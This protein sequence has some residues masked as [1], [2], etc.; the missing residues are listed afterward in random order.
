M[1]E[2]RNGHYEGERALFMI[3]DSLI[4]NCLFD[5]GESPLKEGKNLKVTNSIFGY[6]YPL[7]YNT[8]TTIS[9][10]TFLEMGR[11]GIW[12]GKN[13]TFKDCVFEA[14]KAFRKCE[15]LNIE[16][17]KFLHAEETL[18]WNK[19]VTLEN[20]KAKGDYFGMQIKHAKINNLQLEGNYPFDGASHIHITNSN[21][22]SK[23]AFWNCNDIFVEDSIIDGEYFGWNSENITL[24]RCTII[25]HQGFCY[26][27]GITLIDCKIIDSD[28]TFEYC[29]N[30]DATVLSVIDSI[31]N[32]ISGK[33]VCQGYKEYINDDENIK[34]RQDFSLVVDKN[35]GA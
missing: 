34:E 22:K 25:S 5:N 4:D 18:W 6:K 32:P 11:A 30:I 27:K 8:D 12:Y 7:W 19:D 14:P 23:D 31:K 33:I 9:N 15:N 20:V 16:N 26:M 13:L 1:K 35:L 28:L 24:K 10:S 3:Q 17:T 2:Y 29:E 21:L